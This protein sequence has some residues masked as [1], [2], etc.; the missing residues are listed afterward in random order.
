MAGNLQD[1]L[2]SH[3]SGGLADQAHANAAPLRWARLAVGCPQG[4]QSY[5]Y[6]CNS[7]KMTCKFKLDQERVEE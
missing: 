7:N 3:Q 2:L 1:T 4:R 6:R 5:R